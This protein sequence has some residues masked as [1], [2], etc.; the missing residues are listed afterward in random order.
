MTLSLKRILFS[1]LGVWFLITIFG[2]YFIFNLR[3]NLNFGID[4]VGGTYITL[5]V[6]TEALLEH[7]RSLRSSSGKPLTPSQEQ[8][9]I[10]NAVRDNIEVLRSRLDKSGVGEITIAAHGE[11]N[12]LIELPNV[13]NP[14][15]A[16]AMIGK[17]ALLEVKLVEASAG[18][19][20]ELLEKYNG[21]LPEDR[22][23]VKESRARGYS[24]QPFITYH[25]VPKFTDLTGKLLKSAQ[26]GLSDQKSLRVTPIIAFEFKP[27]GGEKFY[28]L[29]KNNIGKPIALILDNEV[30]TAPI[31]NSPIRESGQITGDFDMQEAKDIALMLRSGAFTAPVEVIEERHIGPSLGET[32]IHQGLIS[33]LIGLG[34]LLLFSLFFYKTAGLFAFIVLLYNLLIILFA[35]SWF[36][37]ALTLP[38]IAGIVLSIGMAIDASI[39][40]YERIKEELASGASL[41]KAIDGGFSGALTVILDANFTHFLVAIVLYYLGAGPIQGF[42]VTMIIGI[43]ATLLTGILLLRAIFNFYT[44]TLGI[45]KLSI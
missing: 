17:S 18:S 10:K 20:T 23:I 39:L 8:D 28:Q 6:K 9:I 14:A 29:T 3:N 35:L 31:A 32:A 16:K 40:I 27:E 15:Q 2:V 34:L 44:T 21:K 1:Q 41:K 11:K 24:N 22:I 13:H 38:G 33:C 25:V 42:A 7:E 12:I 37:A 45:Q 36:Q 19:E 30:I 4:L 5:E 26:A 43:V